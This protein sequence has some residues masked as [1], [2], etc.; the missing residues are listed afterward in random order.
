VIEVSRRSPASA[1]VVWSVLADGFRYAAWVV[2]ASRVRAVDPTWPAVGSRIHHSVGSW[3]LLLDDVTEVLAC[4]PGRALTL[5]A[6]AWPAGEAR[7]ELELTPSD[8]A[9][10]GGCRIDMREDATHGPATL[11]PQSLRQLAIGPRNVESLRRLAYLA[12][13]PLP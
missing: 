11:L 2:G 8:E 7:V 3:P 1:E 13:R 5:Q 9:A 10:P 12:E 4:E 6:R